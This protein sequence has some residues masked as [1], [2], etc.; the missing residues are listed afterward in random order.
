MKRSH[1]VLLLLTAGLVGTLI[2]TL[3]STARS[4]TFPEAK[5]G[6]AASYKVSG[7]LVREEPVVY[8]PQ[9]DA[10]VTLF[11]MM[12]RSGNVAK[13]HLHEAKPTGLE[14]SESIDLYGHF[15]GEDFHADR[16]L[17]KCP[18][19]YNEQNHLLEEGSA[20]SGT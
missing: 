3:T 13:V 16:M 18:S 20:R 12:D 2:A 19:K 10:G 11:T 9:V 5:A 1:V 14:R 7:T 17:M 8:D 6:D 15:D 4:V